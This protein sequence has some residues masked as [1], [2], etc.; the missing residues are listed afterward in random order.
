ME[1]S[2]GD[3]LWV[4]EFFA[5]TLG[6][7]A[8]RMV[9]MNTYDMVPEQFHGVVVDRVSSRRNRRTV[10][11]YSCA[12]GDIAWWYLVQSKILGSSEWIE[13]EF[14]QT[15]APSG[16]VFFIMRMMMDAGHDVNSV[17]FRLADL[18]SFTRR[19][20]DRLSEAD[21]VIRRE[22][23]SVRR[24]VAHLRGLLEAID[25]KFSDSKESMESLERRFKDAQVSS[26]E[27]FE[28][29]EKS[30]SEFRSQTERGMENQTA[31]IVQ[32]IGQDELIKRHVEKIEKGVKN[33]ASVA[34]KSMTT[35]ASRESR[36]MARQI[37]WP[38]GLVSFVFGVL[39]VIVTNW[40][41]IIGWFSR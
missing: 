5:K 7:S 31:E 38:V 8:S 3:V 2:S 24:D 22:Q 32:L 37:A 13:A 12:D 6:Y 40:D 20:V 9:S 34:M 21:D 23:L 28:R 17:S 30:L 18:E 33:V 19:E 36:G 15:T 16:P 41:T 11:P 10:I 4:N 14:V 39:N 27:G 25:K 35:H 29:V 1:L 26:Q